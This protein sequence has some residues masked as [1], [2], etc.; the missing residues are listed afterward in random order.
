MATGW[1]LTPVYRIRQS[2]TQHVENRSKQ[3]YHKSI[4]RSSSSSKAASSHSSYVCATFRRCNSLSRGDFDLHH[5]N[6]FWSVGWLA[7]WT[8][9]CIYRTRLTSLQN[10]ATS[11]TM[12]T[13]A[14]KRPQMAIQDSISTLD[15][16]RHLWE[17][18]ESTACLCMGYSGRNTITFTA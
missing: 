13:M 5:D 7:R 14:A 1:V 3:A 18:I 10:C 15:Y 17:A 9:P 12:L 8:L 2:R 16:G 11:R 6:S 4:L